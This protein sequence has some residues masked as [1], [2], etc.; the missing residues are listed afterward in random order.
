ML[1]GPAWNCCPGASHGTTVFL[2]GPPTACISPLYPSDWA[3]MAV[4]GPGHPMLYV[5]NADGTDQRALA[6]QGCGN[7]VW[8]P[9][10][11]LLVFNNVEWVGENNVL[12]LYTIRP[13][14]SDVRRITLGGD[15]QP[16]WSPDS[17]QI[18]FRSIHQSNGIYLV[19][20]DGTGLMQVEGGDSGSPS[21]SPR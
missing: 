2:G 4:G 14:G 12:F 17:R 7:P 9:D 3:M 6:G 18:V 5:M 20:A 13:D 15:A 1:M 11:S 8:S 10:G 21:W 16:S 19:N